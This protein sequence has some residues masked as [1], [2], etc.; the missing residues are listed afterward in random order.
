LEWKL[1]H[2]SVL[3]IIAIALIGIGLI[4]AT[5]QQAVFAIWNPGDVPE[6]VTGH[7]DDVSRQAFIDPW[8]IPETAM[9][10]GDVVSDLARGTR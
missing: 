8:L 9:G 10:H 2:R 3:G 6:A 5:L 7:G 1:F 4:V